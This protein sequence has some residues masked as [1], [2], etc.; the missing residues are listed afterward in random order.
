M[1]RYIYLL[2]LLFIFVTFVID[3]QQR[4][5]FV[6]SAFRDLDELTTLQNI[7][8]PALRASIV[9]RDS[10]LVVMKAMSMVGRAARSY[11]PF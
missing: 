5:G 3:R 8:F 9:G 7:P 10:S 4:G 2:L 1:H 6:G 11:E